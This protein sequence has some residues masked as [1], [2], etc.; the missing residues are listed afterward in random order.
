MDGYLK[1]FANF[2][3]MSFNRFMRI[4]ALNAYNTK[5]YISSVFRGENNSISQSKILYS[6][7]DFF[8]CISSSKIKDFHEIAEVNFKTPVT[9]YRAIWALAKSSDKNISQALLFKMHPYEELQ[10]MAFDISSSEFL[11]DLKVK[12]LVGL[13]AFAFA[14]ETDDGKILKITN[15]NHFPNRR[16][17]DFFDVPIIQQGKA[18]RTYYYIEDKLSQDDLSQDELKNLVKQIEERGY[19]LRDIYYT[20]LDGECLN[21]IKPEQ[22]GRAKDGK[23]YLLDAG[24]AFPP[25]KPLINVKAFIKKLMQIFK[26]K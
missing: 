21:K 2:I 24:C 18:C 16:K 8:D 23:I 15:G 12:K 3:F 25:E 5:S 4:S 6:G 14:F 10:E 1:F 13:G 19:S 22:F 11:R 9:P 20:T 26:I 7:N 17:P